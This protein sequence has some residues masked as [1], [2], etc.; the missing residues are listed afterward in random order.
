MDTLNR[1]LSLDSLGSVAD[2]T[3][4]PIPRKAAMRAIMIPGGGQIYNRDYW[5]LPFVYAALAGAGY[6]VY[7]NIVRYNNFLDAYYS[8]YNLETGALKP[9]VDRVPVKY[10]DFFY[11]LNGKFTTPEI[12]VDIARRGKDQYRRWRDY[13]YVV[14]GL[15]YALSIIEA[16]V[17]AHMKTFDISEDLTLRAEPALFQPG[18]PAPM[19]GLRL[20]LT[21]R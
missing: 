6:S 2:A 1:T 20:V 19:T 14:A 17:A 7:W 8:F 3:F 12:T 18:L 10:L 11:D 16:N 21:F 5:K 9:G 15:T 4:K 13:A